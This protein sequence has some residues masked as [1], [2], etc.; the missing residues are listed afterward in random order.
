MALENVFTLLTASVYN[1]GVKE[2][3]IAATLE[4]IRDQRMGMVKSKLAFE[5]V[6]TAIAYEIQSILKALNQ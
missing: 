4:H 3:D 6:L 5:F 2:I 1:T